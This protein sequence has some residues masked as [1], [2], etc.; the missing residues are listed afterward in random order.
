M[1]H[2]PDPPILVPKTHG[3]KSTAPAPGLDSRQ[4]FSGVPDTRAVYESAPT[5]SYNTT[6][7][8]HPPAAASKLADDIWTHPAR[9]RDAMHARKRSNLEIPF[10]NPHHHRARHDISLVFGVWSTPGACGPMQDRPDPQAEAQTDWLRT[11]YC[12]WVVSG[13]TNYAPHEEA[14]T[15]CFLAARDTYFEGPG[16]VQSRLRSGGS[17]PGQYALGTGEAMHRA[18]GSRRRCQRAACSGLPTCFGDIGPR[19]GSGSCIVYE[20]PLLTVENSDIRFRYL[21]HKQQ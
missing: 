9:A 19:W 3:L 14:R 1:A 17:R 4:N 21:L 12:A 18:L 6:R 11:G 16:G 7:L 15:A 13:R 2:C 5:P 10:V 8:S 20:D